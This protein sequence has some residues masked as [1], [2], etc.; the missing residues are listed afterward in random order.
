MC[1]IVG[2]L[3]AA[4]MAATIGRTAGVMDGGGELALPRQIRQHCVEGIGQLVD[5][6]CGFFAGGSGGAAR[7]AAPAPRPRRNLPMRF[8]RS[9]AIGERVA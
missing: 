3:S 4:G 1:G 5:Q 7:R 9:S 2:L 8:S 6:R